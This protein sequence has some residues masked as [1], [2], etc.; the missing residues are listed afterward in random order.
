MVADLSRLAE[1]SLAVSAMSGGNTVSSNAAAMT[2]PGSPPVD[3][4]PNQAE[5]ADPSLELTA[6]PVSVL[7][8]G[9]GYTPAP[10][11]WKETPN[12]GQP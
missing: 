2:A 8:S 4:M 1:G 5:L 9:T 7:V 3:R 6:K 11:T 12:G 10:V